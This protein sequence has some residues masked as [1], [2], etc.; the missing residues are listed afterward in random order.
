MQLK[1][2]QIVVR[3]LVEQGVDLVFGFPG[4]TVIDI[5][6]ALLDYQDEIHHVLV[7][8]EQG[9]AHAADGYARATGKVGVCLATS[10]P[11]STNLVTGIAASFMDSTPLVVITGNVATEH[12][13]TDSFQEIDITGVT[14][15]IT[16]H[17][18]F[19]ED[20]NELAHVIREAF[21]LAVSDRP[22]PVLIDVAKDVQQ[23]MGTYDPARPVRASEPRLTDVAQLDAAAA[24]INAC[25]RP[26]VYFGGGV[27]AAGAQQEVIELANRVDAPIACSLM[28]LSAIPTAHPRFLGM[29]GMHGRYAATM[30]MKNADCIIALGCRFNDRSTGDRTRFGAAV[31]IVHI[32]VDGS[33]INKTTTDD[34]GIVGD[35]RLA[36]GRLMPLLDQADHKGW[37]LLVD[38]MREDEASQV[39]RREG[40]TPRNVLLAAD[41]SREPDSC[42]V[43]DVGQ[44]QMWA[45]Q[46]LSFSRPR[47]FVSNGGL[48]AMG[49]GLPAAIGVALAT[50]ART[51][52]VVGDGGLG[53]SVHELATAVSVGAPVTILLINNGTLGM[54]RQW[55]RLFYDKR[56]VGTTLAGYRKTDYVAVAQAFGANGMRVSSLADL[57]EA[58]GEAAACEGPYL[59]DCAIARDELVLPMLAPSGGLDDIIVEVEE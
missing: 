41:E 5:Y 59:I 4:A 57:R 29:E 3:T 13:G 26:L 56:Y 32:D 16:K 52:L 35:L 6:D 38:K 23:A 17:N 33:E 55:Q 30:A 19:V 12:I 39:D 36:L 15:P 11:G 40:L 43:T 7:A 24:C 1:G 34:F 31:H 58:L 50:H 54:V 42:V 18:Y 48:G 51:L 9:A 45:A 49:F 27:V 44:H 25:H 22:G 14:L 20:A 28:G 53:M 21:V 8:H 47:S 46:F 37:S 2:S 10:G